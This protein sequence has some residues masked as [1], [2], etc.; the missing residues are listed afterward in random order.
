MNGRDRLP[1][2]RMRPSRMCRSSSRVITVRARGA[3]L[4]VFAMTCAIR[5]SFVRR[6][7]LCQVFDHCPLSGRPTAAHL[8]AFILPSVGRVS[9]TPWPHRQT[10]DNV[11]N[12]TK[13]S[14]TAHHGLRSDDLG[15]NRL[16]TGPL[17]GDGAAAASP[18]ERRCSTVSSP[19]CTSVDVL[20]GFA[21]LA[22]N[23]ALDQPRAR[24][25]GV[26]AEVVRAACGPGIGVSDAMSL[27]SKYASF[28][29]SKFGALPF[30]TVARTASA[31]CVSGR[32]HEP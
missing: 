1:R 19:F 29:M 5:Q 4:P 28:G 32:A 16:S 26:G 12:S 18:G 30:S 25:S 8:A 9:S 15:T 22:G 6:R 31:N 27:A 20:S 13:K 21:G 24:S 7:T 10:C 23:N 11:R 2:E 3:L 17:L 14:Q